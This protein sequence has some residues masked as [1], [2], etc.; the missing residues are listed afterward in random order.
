M[1][2]FIR[3]WAVVIVVAICSSVSAQDR[4]GP[5]SSPDA[6]ITIVPNTLSNVP[7]LVQA[8]LQN[9]QSQAIK[10]LANGANVQDPVRAKDGNRAGFTPLILAAALS[11]L[12]IALL[13][14][15]H[16]A[17]VTELD[18]FR[19]S[20]FWYAA[21]RGDVQITQLLSKHPGVSDVINIPDAD[22]QRTPLHIAVRGNVPELVSIL[23]IDGASQ[24]QKDILG[25]TPRDYCKRSETGACRAL[26]TKTYEV[27][28]IV[29]GHR[30]CT[31]R[32]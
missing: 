17:K 25:E 26:E 24:D 19:R 13:L 11:E 21:W 20:A 1:I 8:V 14:L 31:T 6:A 28:T 9:D 16:G 3:M 22:L 5:V 30:L 2:G 23:L 7:P 18:D 27:C 12:D 10:A 15:D 4:V 32:R 29:D